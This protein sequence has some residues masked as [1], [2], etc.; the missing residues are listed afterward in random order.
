MNTLEDT[1]A[2]LTKYGGILWEIEKH[3]TAWAGGDDVLPWQD[4]TAKK[5]LEEIAMIRQLRHPL[6]IPPAVIDLQAATIA[7]MAG[8]E[9]ST[10]Q[11]FAQIIH[12]H[13]HSQQ[14]RS[15]A[16]YLENGHQ[17][18]SKAAAA[19]HM[20]KE[21]IIPLTARVI[22]DHLNGLPKPRDLKP[23]D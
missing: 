20:A 18:K 3:I 15:K 4:E 16:W 13:H 14:E 9:E 17:F 12:R 22:E 8:D 21:K 11:Q 1:L 5:L 7:A 2:E 6:E 19:R 23:R 10:K